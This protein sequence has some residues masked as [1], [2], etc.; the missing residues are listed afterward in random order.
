MSMDEYLKIYSL[1]NHTDYCLSYVFTYRD[2]KGV[3]G[4]AYATE[5]DGSPSSA[6]VIYW[7][8]NR[9]DLTTDY[10]K[11]SLNVGVITFLNKDAEVPSDVSKLVFTRE[12]GRSFGA[13]VSE[14]PCKKGDEGIDLLSPMATIDYRQNQFFSP[15]SIKNITFVLYNLQ[16][17]RKYNCLLPP[18]EA[19]CGNNIVEPGEECDCGLNDTECKEQCCYPREIIAEDLDKNVTAKGCTR[20]ANTQCSPS[21]G[22]CCDVH[23]CQLYPEAQKESCRRPTECSYESFCSGRSAK[24]PEPRLVANVTNC[25]CDEFLN[26]Q[27]LKPNSS[28]SLIP[29]LLWICILFYCHL[30]ITL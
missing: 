10:T 8:Y 16:L 29:R 21:E 18:S 7:F 5:I 25:A 13:E 22:P 4:K 19:F 11:K 30:S 26:C 14:K 20:R 23:T 2:F 12:L 24:C 17:N 1:R 15:C 6:C 3:L 27:P 28:S 9:G